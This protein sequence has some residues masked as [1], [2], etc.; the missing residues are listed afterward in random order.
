MKYTIIPFL[1]LVALTCCTARSIDASGKEVQEIR[2]ETPS[3]TK[4]TPFSLSANE[5]E[6][7]RG[8]LQAFLAKMKK[9]LHRPLE[10]RKASLRMKK[11]GVDC[12][13]SCKNERNCCTDP[14]KE[15]K[16]LCK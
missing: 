5:D 14:W 6:E 2:E 7:A 8:R 13:L 16:P 3:S 1:L 9:L 4:D 12:K 10:G 15:G 11:R